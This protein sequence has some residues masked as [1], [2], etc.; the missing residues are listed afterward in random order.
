VVEGTKVPADRTRTDQE[1]S[2]ELSRVPVAP[3]RRSEDDRADARANLKD[4]LDFCP[5]AS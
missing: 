3:H 5:R 4:A 1:A 2:E